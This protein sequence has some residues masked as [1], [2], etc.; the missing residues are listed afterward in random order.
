MAIDKQQWKQKLDG[1][2]LPAVPV[3]FDADGN[4][5]RDSQDAYWKWMADQPVAGAAV[6]VHT[7]RGLNLDKSLREAVLRGWREALAGRLIVAGAG[8]RAE[9]ADDPDAYIR[10]AVAMADLAGNLGADAVLA[11]APV[12]FRGG[13]GQDELIIRYHRALAEV[14]L[15]MIL[16]YLYEAAGGVSYSPEVL[17]QLFALDPVVG[18]K[19][20][21]LDSPMTYQDVAAL[22]RRRYPDTTLI[23]GEDRFLGYSLMAG[24]RSALV[25]MGAGGTQVQADLLAAWI[26]GDFGRFVDLSAKCDALS[27]ATFKAPMEGYIQRMLMVLQCQGVVAPEATFD[28]WGPAINRDLDLAQVRETLDAIGVL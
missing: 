13:S 25:G 9:Y 14:G 8:A 28:P 12:A 3:P 10:D 7:G 17:E 20:A 18:I 21:T 16:F 5:H 22:L 27:L 6:W 4:W 24:S 23:T 19:M 26:G 11:Y 2:L 15:P 1:A